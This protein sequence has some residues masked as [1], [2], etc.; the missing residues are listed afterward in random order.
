MHLWISLFFSKPVFEAE[1]CEALQGLIDEVLPSWR[2]GLRVLKNEDRRA[3]REVGSGVGLF[4]AISDETPTRHGLGRAVL[5]GDYKGVTFFLDS[6]SSTLPPELNNPAVEIELAKVEGTRTSEWAKQFFGAAA[7]R[8][9]L[10]Y[11]NAH[12]QEEFNAK[13][14]VA[15]SEG[16]RAVGVL[17]E[18]SLPGLYWLNFLGRPYMTLIG[19]ERVLSAP[20]YE[21]REVDRGAIIVLDEKPTTWASAEYQTR[22]RAVID[23]LGKELFFSRE[24]PARSTVAPNFD[25]WRRVPGATSF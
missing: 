15:D 19:R 12:L 4:D 22:E 11:A 17:L 21:V 9:P 14:I 16:T 6:C 8:L 1:A 2:L 18:K 23:H 7:E 5:K 24:N 3:G 20:A 10:R 25:K 13:N